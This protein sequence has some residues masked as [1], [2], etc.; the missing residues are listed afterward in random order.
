MLQYIANL[1][2][3]KDVAREFK[4][5]KVIGHRTW[6]CRCDETWENVVYLTTHGYTIARVGTT[7]S[8]IFLDID[9]GDIT[10]EELEKALA[11][12]PDTLVLRGTSGLW[13]K[14]HVIIRTDPITIRPADE[15]PCEVVQ[16]PF[17]EAVRNAFAKVKALFPGRKLKLDPHS[18]RYWQCLYS[19]CEVDNPDP[20]ECPIPG[21]QRLKGWVAKYT[22]GEEYK[23]ASRCFPLNQ[24]A[25]NRMFRREARP[26]VV[27]IDWN[28][29]WFDASGRHRHSIKI[30][31]RTKAEYPL[32]VAATYFARYCNSH[33]GADYGK[34][35]V[36]CAVKTT[37]LA[38][39]DE[40][41]THYSERSADIRMCIGREWLASG[42]ID[43]NTYALN[44]VPGAKIGYKPQNLDAKALWNEFKEQIIAEDAAIDFIY[45]IAEGD[46][47]VAKSLIN[48][49]KFT[50]RSSGKAP[51]KRLSASDYQSIVANATS[52]DNG[53]LLLP[54]KLRHNPNFRKFLAS[55]GIAK[56]RWI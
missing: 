3:E 37:I 20:Q 33:Y 5:D 35:D 36:I 13:Y 7:T 45:R 55:R 16:A 22:E 40:G 12:W 42:A 19:Y 51:T 32:I 50:L 8:F 39:F 23:G 52:D 17:V 18:E 11:S 4:R 1:A 27:R 10:H 41:K 6:Y 54:I 38:Q 14:H 31:S 53:R 2:S 21:S 44:R 15:G 49:Y 48:R 28:T 43:I 56:C 47:D 9:E 26:D 25:L 34:E 24:W 30:G 29:Y 46:V